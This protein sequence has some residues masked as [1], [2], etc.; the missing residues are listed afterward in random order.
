MILNGWTNPQTININTDIYV[1]A[2]TTGCSI[3]VKGAP[4]AYEIQLCGADPLIGAD[5][6]TA[7]IPSPA[8]V[9]EIW[10]LLNRKD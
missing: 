3:F 4:G 8:I 10:R 1:A 5:L 7:H 9:Y 2:S 6:Q